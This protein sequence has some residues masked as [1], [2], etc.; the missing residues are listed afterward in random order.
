MAEGVARPVEPP[1]PQ[2]VTPDPEPP[3]FGAIFIAFA[4]MAIMGFGGVLPH[5]RHALVERRRWLTP[6]EFTEVVALGQ[7]LPG[8][9]IINVAVVIGDRWRGPLGSLV[10]VIGLLASP[11]LV[12]IALGSLYLTYGQHAAVHQALAGATAA[13]AGLILATGWRMAEP[14]VRGGSPLGLGLMAA[15]FA[16]IGIL[17]LP[18]L[19]TLAVLLPLGIALA[20]WK[21]VR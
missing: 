13:A 9:N 21:G 19:P 18:L 16:A 12:V 6:A 15:S 8:G 2:S 1:S 11:S 10:A 4:G 7:F 17:K 14:L 3:T 5:A 20:W